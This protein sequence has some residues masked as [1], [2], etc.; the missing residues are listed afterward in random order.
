MIHVRRGHGDPPLGLAL[1]GSRWKPSGNSSAMKPV[2]SRPSRQR[3]CCISVD[4]NGMLC[5]MPSM[6]KESSAV[7]WALIAA[8]RSGAWVTSLAIIGS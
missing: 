4:R 3:G 6:T 2:D 1:G 8:S 5:R 7:A